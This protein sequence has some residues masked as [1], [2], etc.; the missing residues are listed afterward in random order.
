MQ[1]T[2]ET[3]AATQNVEDLEASETPESI[4]HSTVSREQ[5]RD[6]TDRANVTPRV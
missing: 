4:L 6:R 3:S 2:L 1:S 5:A